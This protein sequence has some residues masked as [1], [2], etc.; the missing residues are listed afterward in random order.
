LGFDEIGIHKTIRIYRTAPN[1]SIMTLIHL[2]DKPEKELVP[3]YHVRLIHSENMTLAYWN[4]EESASMPAHSHPNEQVVNIIEGTF[5]L[6][7]ENRV[8][9]IEHGDVVVIPSNV[10]HWGKALTPCRIIDVFHPVRED[11]R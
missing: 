1:S 2:E 3:G 8:H 6:N 11:Y 10:K 7:V 4:I 5:E 9:I